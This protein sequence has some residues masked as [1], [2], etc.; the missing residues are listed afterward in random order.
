MSGVPPPPPGGTT[1]PSYLPPPA[2][3]P[4]AAQAGPRHDIWGLVSTWL[5]AL[6]FALLFIGVLII[7]AWG[8]VNGG[9][10]NT[11]TCGPT[12]NF[13]IGQ[14]NAIWAANFLWVFGLAAV[15]AGSGLKLHWALKA[16]TS[17][18][19]ED[20]RWVMGERFANYALF[21]LS[22]ILLFLLLSNYQFLAL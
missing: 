10:I 18:R 19:P 21:F 13:A 1:A 15:G 7:V 17:G 11:T 20:Y 12:T 5:R 2:W 4:M 22:I 8:T 14:H 3:I 6:G 16:P 9:C